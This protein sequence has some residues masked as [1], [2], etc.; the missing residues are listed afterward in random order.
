MAVNEKNPYAGRMTNK[1]SQFVEA[2]FKQKAPAK[3][4]V[5]KAGK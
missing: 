5:K 4:K 2:A 3:G 1:N